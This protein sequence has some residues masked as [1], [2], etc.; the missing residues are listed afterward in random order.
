MGVATLCR[1]ESSKVRS[2]PKMAEEGE[3][4]KRDPEPSES[5]LS[6]GTRKGI[7]GRVVRGT[8]GNGVL[9]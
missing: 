4:S 3:S 9:Y 7:E 6:S 2:T 1:F 8:K 5:S